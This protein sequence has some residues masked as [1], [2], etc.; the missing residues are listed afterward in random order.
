MVDPDLE[1]LDRW[2]GGDASAGNQLF[3]RHFADVFRF[4]E[5]KTFGEEDD[6][7]QEVWLQCTLSRDAFRRQS[8][9]RT[10]LFAIARHVLHQYYR[11]KAKA[12]PAIDF[13]E[14][15]I[16]SLS[17]SVGS[18]LAK[19]SDRARLLDSLRKLPVE[20]QTLL[21][22]YYWQDFDRPQLAEIYGV[23]PATIGSR[24]HRAR[25]AMK[26]LLEVADIDTWE[27]VT[28]RKP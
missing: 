20:D 13:E 4:F 11:K 14:I 18:R 28:R 19:H 12:L 27:A 23:E 17:T 6:L 7:G 1:L 24:L 5:G 25:V 15:S 2:C 26:G 22:L 8:T 21:E 16:E 9:F 3:G 10:Y